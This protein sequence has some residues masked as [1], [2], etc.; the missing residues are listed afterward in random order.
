MSHRLYHDTIVKNGQT[1]PIQV[2]LICA[3]SF[4]KET[5]SFEEDRA[6]C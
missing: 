6:K 2:R 5:C 3:E 1:I 4:E